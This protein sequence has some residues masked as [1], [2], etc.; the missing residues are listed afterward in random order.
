M[1]AAWGKRRLDKG[2]VLPARASPLYFMYAVNN[3]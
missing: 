2:F 3:I 1:L